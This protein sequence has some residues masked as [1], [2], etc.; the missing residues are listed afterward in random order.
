MQSILELLNYSSCYICWNGNTSLSIIVHSALLCSCEWCHSSRPCESL[1]KHCQWEEDFSLMLFCFFL[2]FLIQMWG[3]I[4]VALMERGQVALWGYSHTCWIR[5]GSPN[6]ADFC[7]G[8]H[9]AEKSAANW[10]RFFGADFILQTGFRK[11]AADPNM[12]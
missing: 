10:C 7:F 1:H 4:G 8:F 5:C 12:P 2:L 9:A 11:C 3:F 6:S